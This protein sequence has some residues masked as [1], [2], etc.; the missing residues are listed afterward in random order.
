MLCGHNMIQTFRHLYISWSHKHLILIF[1]TNPKYDIYIG[2][3]G[4][5]F[6]QIIV[7]QWYQMFRHLD[8]SWSHK[9]LIFG[10]MHIV[11][12]Y[13][14]ASPASWTLH[15]VRYSWHAHYWG[16]RCCHRE[17]WP[18]RPE[19]PEMV[20]GL[21]QENPWMSGKGNPNPIPG[22]QCVALGGHCDT[23]WR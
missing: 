18:E 8:S 1:G 17:W 15:E 9:H 11:G 20:C 16:R 22:T 19:N 10:T 5:L 2:T 23:S 12:Q 14:S 21:D 4:K 13:P 3:G 7:Y 6:Y